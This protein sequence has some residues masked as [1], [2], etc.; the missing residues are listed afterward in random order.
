MTSYY[1]DKQRALNEL[2]KLLNDGKKLKTN[3]NI[4]S[5]LYEFARN[6]AVS[7]KVIKVQIER[8]AELNQIKIAYGELIMEQ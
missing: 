6:H 2:H 5:L 7:E 8:F 4:E 3:L 1:R